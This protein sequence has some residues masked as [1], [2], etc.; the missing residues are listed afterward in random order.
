MIQFNQRD[1]S[2]LKT[3]ILFVLENILIVVCVAIDFRV[4]P[5]ASVVGSGVD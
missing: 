1:D 2:C 5:L 4:P 3:M